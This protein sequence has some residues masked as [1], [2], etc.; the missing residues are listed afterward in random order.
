MKIH[1][2]EF[3]SFIH[4]YIYSN[5]IQVRNRKIS[6]YQTSNST[7]MVNIFF[8]LDEVKH[9]TFNVF[10]EGLQ[11]I[12]KFQKKMCL[13]IIKCLTER[14]N[15]LEKFSLELKMISCSILTYLKYAFLHDFLLCVKPFLYRNLALCF[16][17]RIYD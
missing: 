1:T 5:E 13:R 3:M 6:S 10:N 7:C 2:F 11:L 17:E 8:I 12:T 4:I 9:V 16:L 15:S 14:E